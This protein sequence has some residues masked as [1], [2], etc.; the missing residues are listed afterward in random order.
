M[1]IRLTGLAAGLALA[2]AGCQT[3]D[4]AKD[5]TSPS[6][7]G[8]AVRT[9]GRQADLTLD[10]GHGATLELA[11]LPAGEFLMGTGDNSLLFDDDER[12]MHRIT[13]TK[14]FLIGKYEVTQVQWEALMDSNP[15]RHTGDFLPVHDISWNDAQEFCKRLAERSGRP[16]RL[17]TEAQWEYACRA[18]TTT[19]FSF[20]DN[21][22][23]LGEYGWYQDNADQGPALVGTKKP[24]P[25]G[26]YDMHG[27]VF[28]WCSDWFD[29]T[30][31]GWGTDKDPSGPQAGAKRVLRG[32][33][34]YLPAWSARS[35]FRAASKPQDS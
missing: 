7:T 25:W 22:E 19:L 16:V 8:A 17:P 3:R 1:T 11:R 33:C 5:S 12:P 32:G 21:Q 20:G 26:L 28:E 29:N 2:L 31:Y 35:A 24:N 4:S 6:K 15:S 18:G 30:Y 34:W 14:P 23:Q 13:I 9:A 27:N 10:L